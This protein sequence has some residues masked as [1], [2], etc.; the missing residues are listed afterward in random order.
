[1]TDTRHPQRTG[2]RFARAWPPRAW[3]IA[4]TIAWLC[5]AGFAL[6]LAPQ[7]QGQVLRCTDAATGQVTYTDG[8]CAQGNRAHELQARKS[9]QQLEQERAQAAAALARMD[10]ELRLQAESRARELAEEQA[11][12][13]DAARRERERSASAPP[14]PARSAECASARSR[15][16]AVLREPGAGSLEHSLRADA[17]QRQADL[18]CL[19]PRAWADLEQARAAARPAVAWPPVIVL[20]RPQ[21]APPAQPPAPRPAITHCNVFRCYDAQGNTYPPR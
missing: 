7:A 1:M 14:D 19:G 9:A 4:W 11:R 15:L 18:A 3:T 16:D 17:A 5:A 8:A 20:G 21:P 2:R 12:R 10:L 6:G 13:D